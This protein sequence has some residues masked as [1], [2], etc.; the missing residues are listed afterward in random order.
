M[1]LLD[2]VIDSGVAPDALVRL[3]IRRLLA[4]R[5]RELSLETPERREAFVAELSRGPIA[6]R[7]EAANAQHYEVPAEF[8][9]AALGPRLKYS[10]CWFDPGETDLGR[11]EERMLALYLERAQ[12]V[13]GQRILDLGC[14]WGSFSLFAA[15]RLPRS[16]ILAV[17]NS[18]VQRR[19]IE[20]RR[21]AAGLRNLE[22]VTC[23]VNEFR[24]QERFD[25]IVSVEMFEHLHNYDELFRRLSAWLAPAG[26]LFVHVFVHARSSYP[27]SER[28][29]ADWMARH[30]FTGGLMPAEDLLPRFAAR[31]ALGLE[32]GY[33]VS[34]THYA[35]TAEAWLRNID[36]RRAEVLAV[37]RRAYGP[38]EA[39]A[40]LERWRVF[41]MACAELWNYRNGEEWFVAHYR[42]ASRPGAMP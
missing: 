34:G 40:R 5:L 24:P 32:E 2:A 3:G 42:F 20:S 15:E 33:R 26:K 1:S 36:R 8:F 27:F 22:V 39:S 13:D 25:R 10:S 31:H 9:V 21:D 14:G 12:A 18:A 30:F 37:F 11:A 6:V 38:G 17:S 19:F 7:T 4:R 41:C 16:R 29:S 23:D 28:G 35:R